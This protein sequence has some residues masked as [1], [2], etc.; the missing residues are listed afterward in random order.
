MANRGGEQTNPANDAVMKGINDLQRR[1]RVLEE[2]YTTLRRKGQ[3]IDENF[4]DTERDLHK[5][6]KKLD[7]EHTEVRR[8]LIDLDDKLDRFLEQ[9]K[10]AASREDVLVLKKYLQLWDPIKY[11]T[12]D[13]ALRLLEREKKRQEEQ[14]PTPKK[15][16]PTAKKKKPLADKQPEPEKESQ[17]KKP[18]PHDQMQELL[19][20]QALKEQ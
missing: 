18:S 15:P 8:M 11:L 13:E 14:Q 5:K 2:R 17:K 20:K 10:K 4:L 16:K 19:K 3:L 7:E 1:L 12:R 6:V 9:A